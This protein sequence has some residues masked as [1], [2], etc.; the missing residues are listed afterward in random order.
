MTTPRVHVR[1]GLPTRIGVNRPMPWWG[2]VFPPRGRG[3]DPSGNSELGGAGPSCFPPRQVHTSRRGIP[4]SSGKAAFSKSSHREG[5][6]ADVAPWLHGSVVPLPEAGP[7]RKR[8]P[9]RVGGEVGGERGSTGQPWA[10]GGVG[11]PPA[12]RS[13]ALVA[14]AVERWPRKAQSCPSPGDP[15]S[16]RTDG[17]GGSLPSTG[18]LRLSSA[19]GREG[20]LELHLINESNKPNA[21]HTR[22]SPR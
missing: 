19:P 10:P 22:A 16:A 15:L 12:P 13:Q 5:V 8:F 11:P 7:Q 21:A 1:L 18:F 4:P 17:K 9:Q 20:G 14:K 6:T 3:R 2:R